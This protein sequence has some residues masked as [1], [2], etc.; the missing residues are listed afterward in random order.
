MKFMHI[1][2]AAVLLAMVVIAFMPLFES[3]PAEVGRGKSS[4]K[5]TPVSRMSRKD[6]TVLDLQI[7]IDD[8]ERVGNEGEIVPGMPQ[9]YET[10]RIHLVITCVSSGTCEFSPF[11]F[12]LVHDGWTAPRIVGGPDELLEASLSSGESVSGWME[13]AVRDGS[14]N[15]ELRYDP[16][17]V[18]ISALEP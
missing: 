14:G 4:P 12:Y 15:L 8:L 9:D 1:S 11:D 16:P 17:P 2:V 10:V 7:S 6:V 3:S 5:P 13:F 18:S